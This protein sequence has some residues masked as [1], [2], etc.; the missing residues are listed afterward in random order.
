MYFIYL[1]EVSLAFVLSYFV[2]SLYL[3]TYSTYTYYSI[4]SVFSNISDWI[5]YFMLNS[6]SLTFTFLFLIIIFVLLHAPSK[7]MGRIILDRRI[8]LSVW[9]KWKGIVLFLLIFDVYFYLFSKFGWFLFIPIIFYW[10]V[11]G[12]L[13]SSNKQRRQTPY[14]KHKKSTY[15]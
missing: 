11:R 14:F 12:I 4:S 15:R 8:P 5:S 1:I 9:E 13:I 6:K 10:S 2:R 7:Y 3:Y